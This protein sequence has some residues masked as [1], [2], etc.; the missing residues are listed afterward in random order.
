MEPSSAATQGWPVD[1]KKE[2]FVHCQTLL[3]RM[4]GAP[5]RRATWCAVSV[6]ST[7]VY[8]VTSLLDNTGGA[9]P[10]WPL[11]FSGALLV[12]SL[13]LCGYTPY[14]MRRQA[15]KQ[16]EQAVACGQ[17]YYGQLYVHPTRIQKIGDTATASLALD[18]T[19]FFIE[20]KD[21]MVFAGRSRFVLALPARCMSA[22]MAAAVR[23]AAD[24]LPARN[25]RF[26]SRLQP[27]GL[28]AEKPATE[29]VDPLWENTIRFTGEEFAAIT[30]AQITARYWKTAPWMAV[31]SVLGGVAFGWNGQTIWPCVAWFLVCF[32]SLTLFR[33]VLPRARA[34]GMAVLSG[35]TLPSMH[36]VI[37]ARGV[38]VT[39]ENGRVG[40]P[41]S[42]VQ[43]VYDKQPFVEI[44]TAHSVWYIPKR[45][46]E[47]FAVFSAMIDGCR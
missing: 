25:R 10:D 44:C 40:V 20:E 27:K 8:F 39:A 14:H 22:D 6:V 15:A 11:L 43:H 5:R 2:E 42:A 23:Q 46:I 41:W 31:M 13:F 45:C 16:Y 24:R 9:T 32:A 37:D 28:P 4:Q 38:H 18:E 35:D 29:K 47:D 21:M 12:L 3:A 7:A 33:L 36:M 30:R 19:T 1:L 26:L 34:K 17:D